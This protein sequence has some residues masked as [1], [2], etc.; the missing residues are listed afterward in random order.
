MKKTRWIGWLALALLLGGAAFWVVAV[1]GPAAGDA[2]TEIAAAQRTETVLSPIYTVD[3]KY[4]S[5]M[6]PYS[7]QQILLDGVPEPG[8]E[9]FA[10]GEDPPPPA[11]DDPDLLWITGYR[12]VMVGADGSEPAAQEFMCHSNLDLDVLAH[13][14][15]W[16]Q[17]AGFGSRLFTLSQGQFEVRFPPG[18]GI[19]VLSS[20]TLSLT[21][22]VLNLNVEGPP[23]EVRHKVSVEYLRD[24]DVKVPMKA[25]FP[26]AAYGLALVEG[27]EGYFGVRRPDEEQH[28][29]GCLV[30][31][32]ASDHEYSDG[33]GRKFTGHWVVK[34]GREVN[35]TL[36]TQLMQLPYDTTIHYIA[37]HLHPF[38]ESLEL[39]DLT[40][41]ETL[42]LSSARNYEDKI[43]LS[44]VDALTSADGIPVYRDHEYEL[45]STYNNTTGEDQDSMA[46]MYIYL[47]DLEFEERWARRARRRG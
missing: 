5:M 36:V 16:G 19:P 46:V 3:R 37:V 18:F 8:S 23:F 25:L 10:Q 27:E 21:T 7:E 40:A 6:G 14:E 42:F 11:G 33:M 28:G 2:A 4:R 1:G 15:L 30:G 35:R 43:G 38:A 34:P 29:P 44:H 9:D 31:E 13:E 12:A 47:R 24:R 26:T 17:A 32:N 39:R 41:G 22:Q 20:E 45:V